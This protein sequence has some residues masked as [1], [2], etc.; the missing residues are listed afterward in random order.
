MIADYVDC[1][2]QDTR[3]NLGESGSWTAFTTGYDWKC[4]MHARTGC[5]IENRIR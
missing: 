1:V 3:G 4:G 5:G 2:M